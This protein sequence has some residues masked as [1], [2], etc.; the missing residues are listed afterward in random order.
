M[1][2]LS[3]FRNKFVSILKMKC[4]FFL[5][6]YDFPANNRPKVTTPKPAAQTAPTPFITLL[7]FFHVSSGG[8]LS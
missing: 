4:F 5:I 3:H 7:K 8:L 2:H 6:F 1:F